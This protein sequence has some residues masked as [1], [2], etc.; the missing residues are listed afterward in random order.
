MIN[1]KTPSSSLEQALQSKLSFRDNRNEQGRT[2]QR[3]RGRG[4][5]YNNRSSGFRGRGGRGPAKEGKSH[6]HFAPRGR[7][8]GRGCGYNNRPGFDKSN[9]QCYLCHKFGHYNNECRSRATT[10]AGEQANF[11][12]E[13]TNKV[14]PT[15]LFVHHGDTKNQNN[16]WYLDSRASNHMCGKRELFVELDE[17]VQA[18]V[19]FGDSSK[20]PVKRRGN[21]LIKLKNGDHDYISNVYYVPAMKNNT[22]SMGQL[23]EKGYNVSM[24]DC[25]LTIKDNHGNLI[26]Q[27]RMSKNRMFALNTQH[28]VLKC[29]SAIIKDK[30]WLWHLRFGHLNFGSLKLLSSKNM[31]KRLPHIAHT[32]EVCKSCIL[33]K[34]HRTSFAKEVKWRATKP[35]ELV[36]TDVCGPLKP[37]SN[38]QNRYFLT[39]IDD[40]SRKTWVYFLKRKLEV[41]SIFKEFKVFVEK[42]SGYYIKTL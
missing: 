25:H 12:E 24:K 11:A 27:A 26:A 21:I 17:T 9:V 20:T 6:P 7:A 41:F 29:L 23:L 35:L 38:G 31:V 33:G 8:R 13:E 34:H 32:N 39:F 37:M 22:L 18:Q 4:R 1:K 3:S 15:V 30:D 19:S 42:Q 16:V 36:H 14:G 5:G 28:D 10:E 2:S 40:Y